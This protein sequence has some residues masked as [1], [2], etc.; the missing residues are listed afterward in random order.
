VSTVKTTIKHISTS[1]SILLN[2]N[3]HFTE[4]N[5][6][7]KL[8][9]IHLLCL[10]ANYTSTFQNLQSQNYPTTLSWTK[11]PIQSSLPLK[12]KLFQN[13]DDLHIN[14][15][16]ITASHLH[17]SAGLRVTQQDC[18]KWTNL[19]T[20]VTVLDLKTTR[21]EYVE[22]VMQTAASDKLTPQTSSL[23]SPLHSSFQYYYPTE[24][25]LFNKCRSHT[26]PTG[27]GK[28]C[29]IVWGVSLDAHL[30]YV[31]LASEGG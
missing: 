18:I 8:P 27:K 7:N 13:K 16:I 29:H 23:S 26:I 11:N 6:W 25:L 14:L 2:V 9:E 1:Y 15:Y 12:F 21:Q 22:K 10:D 28:V 17:H 5:K 19:I 31:S 24:K 30:S 20:L 3:N 4:I